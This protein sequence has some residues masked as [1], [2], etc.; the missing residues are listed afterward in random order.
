MTAREAL[1]V[2]EGGGPWLG[3]EYWH[4]VEEARSALREKAGR[5]TSQQKVS[6]SDQLRA[7]EE[8]ASGDCSQLTEL[9]R[10]VLATAADTVRR[11]MNE[12]HLL[13]GAHVSDCVCICCAV[14]RELGVDRL[15]D[16]LR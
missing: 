6:L 14:L 10:M 11:L 12:G 16:Q 4:A 5:E 2:L 3:V 7:I 13:Y 1:K 8:V 9:G 15:P